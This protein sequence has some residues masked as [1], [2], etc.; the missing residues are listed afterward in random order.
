MQVQSKME[1]TG[2]INAVLALPA[3]DGGNVKPIPFHLLPLYSPKSI[4]IIMGC[5]WQLTVGPGMCFF[6]QPPLDLWLTSLADATPG[7]AGRQI[8]SGVVLG[9]RCCP[10]ALYAGS[11]CHLPRVTP[12]YEGHVCGH[13]VRKHMT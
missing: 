4:A 9:S 6:Q 5:T 11:Q 2:N 1:F 10:L 3:P 7:F 12:V 8:F 13:V